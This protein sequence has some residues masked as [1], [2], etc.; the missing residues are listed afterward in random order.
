MNYHRVLNGSGKIIALRAL[1][2]MINKQF[3]FLS[4]TLLLLPMSSRVSI[5]QQGYELQSGKVVIN[6]VGHWQ[7]WQSVFKTIDITDEG[8]R[9]AFLHK[10]TTLDLDGVQVVVPGI[11]AVLNAFEFDGGLRD[12]G[13][14]RGSVV[15]LMDGRMDTYWEPDIDDP[16]ED[17][18][19]QIDLGRTVSATRIVLKFVG[20]ELGDPFL[21]FKVTTSQGE[22]T[23]GPM[24]Y[25]TRFTTSQPT[26]TERVFEIDLTAQLPTK[27]PNTHGDFTGDVIRYVGVGITDSDF[28]KARRVSQTDYERLSAHEKGDVEY[29][30]REISGQERILDGKEDWDVLAG[31]DKQGSV[32][33]YRHE[34]PRLAEIEVWTIGDNIGTG[35]LQRGGRATSWENNGAEGSVV[36][37]DFFGEVVYWPAQGGYNPDKISIRE[38]ADVERSLFVDLGGSFF[39]DNIRVLSAATSPPGPFRAYRLQVSDGSTN[40]GGELSWKTVGSLK[41]IAG[42]ETYHDFKFPITKVEHL[43]YT[44]RLYERAGRHGLSEIQFFGEGFMPESQ[45]TSVFEGDSPFIELSRNPQ[46]LATI[47]W[48]SD[49]PRDTDLL[50]Q[51]R[52]GN[53]VEK[54]TRYY[55]KN[56]EEY[57]GT[58]DEAA[59]AY[60]TDKEFF[61]VNSVGP[62]ISETIPG[63]DWS[64]WSQPYFNSGDKITSPSP[65]KYVAIR[66]TFLTDDPMA[67]ATLRSVSLNFVTPVAGAIF[68]EVL[69]ARLEGIGKKQNLSYYV[70]STFEGNSRGFDDILIEAP[71]GVDM[72]LMQAIVEVTGREAVTYSQG[73]EGFEIVMNETDSL[74]IR[75]PEPIKTTS[76]S[77]LIEVQ[78]ESTIFRYNTFFIGST[79]HSDFPDSWQRVDDGDANG[80]SDS[81]TT[82]VLALEKGELLGDVVVG[83]GFTPNGDGINDNLEIGFSLMRIGSAAP[84]RA[85][86]YDL[87]GRLVKHLSNESLEAGFH[88]MVWNGEDQAGIKALPGVY[89]LRIDIDVDSKSSSNTSLNRIVHVAY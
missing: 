43:A 69:P 20:E 85:D 8:V 28:G 56:G 29:Y 5:G 49:E 32:V 72:A 63:N 1:Q 62:A 47:E 73:S 23:I 26:K 21:Q 15:N 24:L 46:N 75:L 80:M 37:G 57:P 89:L 16:L 59:E 2:M 84:V 19:V 55:K 36:D 74:W 61:G 70:K 38:P 58:E 33:Y 44:Y 12:A 52:T 48:E 53:T 81:E 67:A 27:W 14:N 77:A 25:R 7:Q 31:T 64:S 10:S 18:W 87:G 54:I 40:A 76:G 50:L 17:W 51:T 88:T 22:T 65:R 71:D 42:G 79:G 11:N 13:S 68:G 39:V 60:E 6:D 34:V 78:F 4:W 86:I 9:P 3:K 66:A 30:R 41:D 45:I 35:V 83:N 82:V